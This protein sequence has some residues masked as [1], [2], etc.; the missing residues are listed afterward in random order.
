MERNPR[1]RSGWRWEIT[2]L[3]AAIMLKN[4]MPYLIDK[5]S[6]AE[7]AV[8]YDRIK[9]AINCRGGKGHT[10]ENRK[11]FFDMEERITKLKK[12]HHSATL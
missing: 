1:C 12:V 10:A 2:G 4:I 8:E 3:K 11:I 9:R 7:I 6:Q 5:K